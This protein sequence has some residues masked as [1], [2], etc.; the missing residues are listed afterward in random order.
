[1]AMAEPNIKGI[2]P[3]KV[4]DETQDLYRR[5]STKR[6]GWARHVKEDREFRFQSENLK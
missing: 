1:M 4:V 5:Y 2:D 6:D 3:K